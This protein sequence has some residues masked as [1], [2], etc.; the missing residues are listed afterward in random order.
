MDVFLSDF[1]DDSISQRVRTSLY[2]SGRGDEKK[3]SASTEHRAGYESEV[4]QLLTNLQVTN[5]PLKSNQSCLLVT[6]FPRLRVDLI[7]LPAIG[8]PCLGTFKV[9]FIIHRFCAS[10]HR[11]RAPLPSSLHPNSLEPPSTY[12]PLSEK[13]SVQFSCSPFHFGAFEIKNNISAATIQT[14]SQ[15]RS[16]SL[17]KAPTASDRTALLSAQSMQTHQQSSS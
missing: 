10:S 15:R 4:N 5:D 16:L 12:V 8:W 14:L 13:N 11:I 3:M 2:S 7:V 17:R 1:F 6:T 9:R